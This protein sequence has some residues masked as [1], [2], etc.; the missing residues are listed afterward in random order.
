[1][2][3]LA[4]L[5]CCLLLTDMSF[6]AG[7]A[8]YEYSGRSTAMGGAV[9][10]ND[11]EPA[12]LATNP[13]LITELD[14]V[15]AQVSAT[16]VRPEATTTIAGS[17]SSFE[18]ETFFLPSAYATAKLS[19]QISFGIGAFSRY[20][21]GGK[22]KNYQTWPGSN[23]AYEVNLETISITPTIAVHA[24]DEWSLAMGLEA[25]TIDFTQKMYMQALS[26]S[27]KIHGTGVAWGGNYSFTYRPNWAERWSFG[28]MYR[29]KVK[30]EL[31]GYVRTASGN[32]Y[33]APSYPVNMKNADALGYITLPDSIS[34]GTTF[35]ATDNWTLEAGIVGTFWS[36][37]DQILI[38]Y[39][40][41]FTSPDIKN[42]KKYKDVIRVNFGTE[43]KINQ[44]WA[45]RAGYTFDQ[46]PIND[47]YMD[48]LVPAD[49]RHLLS[50]GVGYRTNTWSADLGYSHIF[51]KD[52]SGTT[53]AQY[54]N[55]P[56]KY[57]DGSS[58][59]L[60]LTF[61]YKF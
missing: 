13:S 29:T 14:R 50:A 2:K 8:L 31:S 27:I 32:D 30:Q 15:Q 45:V 35:R 53:S 54:S 36:S 20:G 43:Y 1:M 59:I 25:M 38:E 33:P 24:S 39:K 17:T 10:A 9:M 18:D 61:G 12:S 44:N 40:N 23:L 34:F 51:I 48:T 56:A 60:S 5:M 11:A 22:Y 52:L 28:G 47:R 58:D 3:K 16:F 26:D 42:Q 6:G 37:Y 4:V 57:T 49:D 55:L 41:E 46:S 21:L 19:D 7:F